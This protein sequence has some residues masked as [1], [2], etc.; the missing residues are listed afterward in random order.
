MDIF[1]KKDTALAAMGAM[2]GVIMH[3]TILVACTS[4]LDLDIS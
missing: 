2:V 1:S 4:I 3:S